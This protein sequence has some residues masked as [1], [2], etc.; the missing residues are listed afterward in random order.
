M[1]IFHSALQRIVQREVEEAQRLAKSKV[2]V[3]PSYEPSISLQNWIKAVVDG[4]DSR[5][6]RSRHL[7]VLGGILNGLSRHEDEIVSSATRAQLQELFVKAVNSALFH[8]HETELGRQCAALALNYTF[9]HLSDF[10]RSHIQYDDLLPVLMHTLLVSPEGFGSGTFLQAIDS[11]VRQS[12]STQFNWPANSPSYIHIQAILA[13]PM[14]SSI[15]P[16]SRLIAHSVECVRDPW[17]VS[18]L[19]DDVAEFCNI[20]FKGWR[21]NKI[22][23]IEVAEESIYL[24]Q[25]ARTRTLPDLW[26]LLRSTLFGLVIVLRSAIGRLLADSTLGS[27]NREYCLF[28]GLESTDIPSRTADCHPMS[29]V[30]TLS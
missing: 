28:I 2:I 5:A 18:S 15:G 21:H 4:L 29:A 24:N 13:N 20:M 30:T 9:Q 26:K 10:E 22:S 14:I 23:E 1:G 8:S 6:P 17:L 7:L 3:P 16:L 19:V 25:E 27:N 12:S 11:D